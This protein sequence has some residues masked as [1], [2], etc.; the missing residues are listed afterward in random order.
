M[1]QK[2]KAEENFKKYME[3]CPPESLEKSDLDELMVDAKVNRM[4]DAIRMASLESSSK[5][6]KKSK[7]MQQP[8]MQ[9]IDQEN[10][11]Q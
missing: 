6:N 5:K 8:G 1:D 10:F 7:I 9:R 11:E 4:N 3:L 2:D